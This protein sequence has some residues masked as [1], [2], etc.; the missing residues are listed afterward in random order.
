MKQLRENFIFISF[1]TFVFLFMLIWFNN[2][3]PLVIY[4]SDDWFYVSY[5]RTAIPA[6]GQWNPSRIFPETFSAVPPLFGSFVIYP[7]LKDYI[8][9][10]TLSYAITIAICISIYFAMFFSFIS[11]RFS[12]NK[13]TALIISL[14][15]FLLHF[16]IFKDESTANQHMFYAG[17]MTTFFYYT[18]GSILNGSLLFYFIGTNIN[19]QFRSKQYIKNAFLL[20]AIYL[21][22]FSNL[23]QSIIFA[24]YIGV[25]LLFN[26]IFLLKSTKK[27]FNV[28]TLKNFIKDNIFSVAVL[29]GWFLCA[30]FEAGGDRAQAVGSHPLAISEAA[31]TLF[32]WLRHINKP[33]LLFC[34]VN[35]ILALFIYFKSNSKKSDFSI[36]LLKLISSALLSTVFL[37]LLGAKTSYDYLQSIRAVFAIPFFGLL[38]VVTALSYILEKKPR[39]I[40]Y[41]PIFMYIILTSAMAGNNIYFDMNSYEVSAYS[42]K[43]VDDYFIEQIVEASRNSQ[44]HL[45]LK[46]PTGYTDNKWPHTHNIGNTVK[47]ALLRHGIIQHDLEV[48]VE[49]DGSLNKK[50][51][52]PY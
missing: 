18:M 29:I 27:S 28:L 11:R 15:F 49:Y 43:A 2:I 40:L 6:I 30:L 44:D 9:S 20:P 31:H 3:H 33:S 16:S 41:V 13:Q 47:D 48:E 51:N 42:A 26:F 21:A 35:I 52:L 1:V 46:V 8:A 39:Y 22:I 45:V 19:E 4:D 14:A 32:L 7:L 24:G 12:I 36:L 5:I 50:F 23:F 37:L 38:C 10:I 34:A 17:S 25:E